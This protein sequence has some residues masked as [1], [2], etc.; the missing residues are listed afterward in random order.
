MRIKTQARHQL[1][2]SGESG[3]TMIVTLGVLFVSSL[4]MAA[5][6]AARTVH[7][8][9]R[10][11]A[12]VLPLHTPEAIVRR[13]QKASSDALDSASLIKSLGNVGVTVVAPE[14]RTPEYLAKFIPVE[15]EKWAGPIKAS[16]V[17]GE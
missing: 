4:L 11:S 15:I 17:Q 3:F 7:A 10:L 12:L 2:R 1:L 13:L 6:F 16:G 8:I 9:V 14:R 5:A